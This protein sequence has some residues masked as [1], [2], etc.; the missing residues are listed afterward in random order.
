MRRLEL[1]PATE[2]LPPLAVR[3]RRCP[4]A[5]VVSLQ[6]RR[7]AAAAAA[8]APAATTARM[9]QT[10]SQENATRWHPLQII[11][12]VRGTNQVACLILESAKTG[13]AAETP[14]FCPEFIVEGK[15][16]GLRRLA[17]FV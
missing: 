9:A 6:A 3:C 15:R 11:P 14:D 16:E 2:R 13:G 10:F 4:R 12:P 1:I 17:W 8:A 5:R 7:A